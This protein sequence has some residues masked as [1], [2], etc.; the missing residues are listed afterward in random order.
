MGR[1]PLQSACVQRPESIPAN[2]CNRARRYGTGSERAV[3]G[4]VPGNSATEP[5]KFERTTPTGSRNVLSTYQ[6]DEGR[7]V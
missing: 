6:L 5:D 7:L 4:C 2:P 1:E 3:V